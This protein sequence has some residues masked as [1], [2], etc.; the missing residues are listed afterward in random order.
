MEQLDAGVLCW[1]FDMCVCARAC[2]RAR[3]CVRA[4]VCARV[5]VCMCCNIQTRAQDCAVAALEALHH[6][7]L[8]NMVRL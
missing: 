5:S 8:C 1:G 7:R 4:C 3:V 6:E 2:V